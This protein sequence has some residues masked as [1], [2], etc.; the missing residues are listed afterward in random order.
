MYK[1]KYLNIDVKTPED[2]KDLIPG[3]LE[4][5][6]KELK[7]LENFLEKQKFQEIAKIAHKLKGHGSSFGF[8]AISEIGFDLEKSIEKK[9]ITQVSILVDQYKELLSFY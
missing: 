1:N 4:R 8:I 5:R 9:E 7:L 6:K 2:L 3:F